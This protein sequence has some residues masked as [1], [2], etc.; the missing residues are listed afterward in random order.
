MTPEFLVTH[1]GGFH[2]DELLSSVVLTRLFPEARIVR[3]RAPEWI[4]PLIVV[5]PLS[6]AVDAMRQIT[7][8]VGAFPFA[9]D[10]AFLVIFAVVMVGIAIPL[11]KRE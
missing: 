3:S 11:F 9:V 5:N 10:V 4:K 7:I 6:Y 2:A 8:G 1:S